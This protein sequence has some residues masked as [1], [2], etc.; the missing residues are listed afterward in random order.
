MDGFGNI[1]WWGFSPNIDL[2]E[3]INNKRKESDDELNIL[4]VC[5]GDQRHIMRTIAE[6]TKSKK[7]KKI[8][9][10][11]YE[12]MLELYARDLLLLSIA[13]E[14]PAKRGVQEK[15]ELFME[16]FGNLLIRDNTQKF[17]KKRANDFIKF[18]TDLDNFQSTNLN[19][20]DLNLL[21]FKERDFLEGIFKFWRLKNEDGK[22]FFPAE[23]C[24]EHR[25]RT[26]HGTRYDTR[27]NGFDWDFSMKLTD[28]KHAEVIH[29]KVYGKWRET[30]VAFDIRDVDYDTPNFTLA[31]SY[32]MTDPRS[33][34]KTGR[35]GYFGDTIV[36][37]YIS[38]GIETKNEKE[39]FKKQNKLYQHT[40]TEITKENLTE[41]MRAIL[42]QSDIDLKKYQ[43]K[44]EAE[45]TSKMAGAKIQEIIEEEDEDGEEST[46]VPPV[47]EVVVD[48][49]DNFTLNDYK[50]TFL[51]LTGLQ[52]LGTKAKYDNLFDVVYLANNGAGCLNKTFNNILRPESLVI[53]ETAKFMIELSNDKTLGFS[54]KMREIAKDCQLEELQVVGDQESSTEKVDLETLNYLYFV[55][56]KKS[57]M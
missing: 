3:N 25:L 55:N 34:E 24:W 2:L 11:V 44:D 17:I 39:F 46:V 28:R 26:Y 36:G 10:Y 16:V 19:M 57:D 45:M 37:P 51:P 54:K 43:E 52:D 29:H 47:V 35:R 23:K 15:T 50:V 22:A 40:G 27:K 49:P 38:Y 8:H 30:G 6:Q 1:N 12:K 42:E 53:V 48:E 32:L 4:L 9:F 13:L 56:S 33:G 14:H 21:K 41:Y 5:A 18:I 20:F 7:K 31:S